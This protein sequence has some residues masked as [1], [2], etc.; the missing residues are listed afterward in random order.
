[1]TVPTHIAIIMD[2]NGRWASRQGQPRFKGHAQGYR[3]LRNILK[4]ASDMGVKY[5]TVYAFSSENFK[6]PKAEVDFL[7]S[8]FAEAAAAELDSLKK[9]NVK[10]VA[11]GRIDELP[12]KVRK[13]FIRD[14][15]ET[16]TNTGIVFN[17]AVTYG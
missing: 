3:N 13:M 16:S 1:M 11:S 4:A 15:E 10:V 14:I 12:A 7:M 2:G 8:L 9:E 5:L 17:I 6:R